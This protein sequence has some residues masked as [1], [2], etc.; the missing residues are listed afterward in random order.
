MK[1]RIFE[2]FVSS[3]TD[4]R[5]SQAL[6]NFVIFKA[7]VII[8]KPPIIWEELSTEGHMDILGNVRAL[9]F[10]IVLV[11]MLLCVYLCMHKITH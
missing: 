5:V 11:V 10:F 9:Y 6:K 7:N 4:F 8:G 1:I 3:T 2:K